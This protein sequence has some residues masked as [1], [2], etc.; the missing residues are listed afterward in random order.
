IGADRAVPDPYTE[1]SGHSALLDIAILVG[2]MLRLVF[3]PLAAPALP[4]GGAGQP[5][6]V[7]AAGPPC[8]R[9]PWPV[10]RRQA[11]AEP[12]LLPSLG[13]G[14]V[15]KITSTGISKYS[16]ICRARHRLGL[17]SL[18]SRYPIVW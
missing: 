6:R 7:N 5:P 1:L 11:E 16:A 8:L 14:T 13:N 12:L 9:P 10:F 2:N 18:R 4:S 3:N 17:Y 15:E